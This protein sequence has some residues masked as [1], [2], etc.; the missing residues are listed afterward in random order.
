M[1]TPLMSVTA[2]TVAAP[3]ASTAR[4]GPWHTDLRLTPTDATHGWRSIIEL[5][6]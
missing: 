5:D 1:S 2:L 6:Q 4:S 3:C